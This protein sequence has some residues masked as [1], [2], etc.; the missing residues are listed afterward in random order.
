VRFRDGHEILG[1]DH[2]DG[3]VLGVRIARRDAPHLETILLADLVVDATG[4]AS[5]APEWLAALGCGAVEETVVDAGVA[6]ASALYRDVPLLPGGDGAVLVTPRAPDECRSGMVVPVEGGLSIVTLSGV[7]GHAPPTDEAGFLEFARSLRAP[8]VHDA[9]RRARRVSPIATTRTTA[10]RLRHYERL[11]RWPRGF[12][13]MGD[14]VCAFNPVYGQGMTV[15]A[16]EADLLGDL[17]RTGRF[18]ERAFLRAVASLVAPVWSTATLED[19]RYGG[20]RGEAPLATRLAHRYVDAVFALVPHDAWASERVSRVLQ[21]LEPSS[22][23]FAPA[24]LRRI[25]AARWFGRR[26]VPEL[27][28][29]VAVEM[30]AAPASIA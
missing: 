5:R 4:R 26:S 19:F 21:L 29:T 24:M 6:Y 8:H 15:A 22:A 3:R 14:A 13:A 30:D 12:I 23:L 20:T 9:I 27:P 18:R 7:R 10:N 28:R 2:R 25:V 17:L 16:M 1:L 11:R